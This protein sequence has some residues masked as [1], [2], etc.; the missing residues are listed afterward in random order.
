M[1]AK[2]GLLMALFIW[3]CSKPNQE[4]SKVADEHATVSSAQGKGCRTYEVLQE[5]LKADPSLQKRMNEIE[6]FTDKFVHDPAAYRLLPDGTLELP[7]VVNLLY[8]KPE[9]NISDRQINS[10]ID[11]LNEDFSA[12]NKDL[13]STSTY[14]SVK[15]GNTK[16]KFVLEKVVRKYTTITAFYTDNAMKNSRRGGIDATSPETTLNIWVCNMGGGILGYAQFPGGNKATDGVVIT[17]LAFGRGNNY[18][19]YED[20]DKGRTA[21]HEVGH[22]FNLSHIWGDRKCGDDHVDDTPLHPT[23][24]FGCPAPNKISSCDGSIEMTMNYMDYTDD[25]C[26]YMFTKGQA[27][28]M[29]ATF[30]IGGPRETLR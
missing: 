4:I 8:N 7:V 18:D 30:A 21:T 26:M 2:Y 11:V 13:F 19:L 23:Y 1:K 12:T 20:Y 17:T 28:R 15:S 6:S 3:S 29:Q 14:N 10:Q 22:Y 5:Q 27:L 24:N 16:I 25:A 9:E